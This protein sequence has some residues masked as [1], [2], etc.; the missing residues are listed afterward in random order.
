MAAPPLLLIPRPVW[1]ATAALLAPYTRA[2][3]EAGLYWYGIRNDEAAVV[4]LVGIPAQINNPR[5]FAVPDDDLAVLSRNVPEPLL[6]VA[7]LHIHPGVDTNHSDYD[8]KRA[9]SRKILSLVLPSY[10]HDPKLA[11]AAVHECRDGQW[12]R[13]GDDEARARV[14]IIPEL[15]DTRQ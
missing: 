10:G 5:N 1:L 2:Q 4:S 14:R 15:I 12:L 7:A 13:L 9:V 11:Q 8:D 3:V 6:T